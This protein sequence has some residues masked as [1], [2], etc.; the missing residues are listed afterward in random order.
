MKIK[1]ERDIIAQFRRNKEARSAT[2]EIT[3]VNYGEEIT[4]NIMPMGFLESVKMTGIMR[5]SANMQDDDISLDG[6]KLGWAML[7]IIAKHVVEI[8]EITVAE[9]KE[10]GLKTKA[11]F[12][13]SFFDD[14]CAMHVHGLITAY[15]DEIKSKKE[16]EAAEAADIAKN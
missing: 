3:V 15:S 2:K 8:D 4:L 10:L 9:L 6:S 5:L 1:N 7:D 13:E 14:K 11:E 16:D 12:A